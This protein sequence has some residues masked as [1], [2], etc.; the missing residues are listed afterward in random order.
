MLE[1]LM[2]GVPV[3]LALLWRVSFDAGRLHERRAALRRPRWVSIGNPMPPNNF[4]ELYQQRIR[5]GH[6]Q[7]MRE[8]DIFGVHAA[9]RRRGKHDDMVD[10]MAMATDHLW[11]RRR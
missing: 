2:G 7:V 11:K 9:A 3:V 8:L 10:A 5:D 1:V 6:D 4:G